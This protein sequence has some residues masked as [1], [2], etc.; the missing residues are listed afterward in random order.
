MELQSRENGAVDVAKYIMAVMVVIIHKN[1]LNDSCVYGNYMIAKVI[2]AIAVPFFFT[3]SSYYFFNKI[4]NDKNDFSKFFSYEKRLVILYFFWSLVYI[5]IAFVKNHTGH[6]DEL[7]IKIFIGQCIYWVKAFFLSQSFIHLWYINTLIVSMAIV[8]FLYKK[9]DYKCAV[10]I[11]LVIFL[12]SHF[13]IVLSENGIAIGKYYESYC[14][15][16]IRNTLEKGILCTSIGLFL[17]KNKIKKVLKFNVFL[18]TVSFSAMVAIGVKMF[19][20][21]EDWI[22]TIFYFMVAITAMN[23]FSICAKVKT[24][25][26][27]IYRYLRKFSTVIYFSHLLMTTELFDFIS[28]NFNISLLK[29]NLV[30][31]IVTFLFGNFVSFIFVR[32]SMMKK[33]RLINYLM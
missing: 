32:L 23:I 13:L 24:K 28:R 27:S 17:S 19:N 8:Y 1:I 4:D 26:S 7:S 22:Q 15:M 10:L 18:F 20:S 29:N 6:Y 21:N 25:P 30:I 9:L 31:F 16:V 3:A 11:C 33:Y 14:P 2:C 5:P 12:V